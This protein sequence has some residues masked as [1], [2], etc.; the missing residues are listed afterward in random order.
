MTSRN[1]DD[2]SDELEDAEFSGETE[3]LIELRDEARKTV[4]CQIQTLGD[5]D[6]KASKIFRL[7]VI[8]IGVIV[9][10][11]SIVAQNGTAGS[12][13]LKSVE[14]F[15]NIYMQWS[16]VA[17]VLSTVF[18]ATTYTASELDVGVSSTNMAKLLKSDLPRKEIEQLL[19][20][21]YITR[22]NFNRSENIR[23]IPLLQLTI[24]LLITAVVLFALG[25][26][27]ATIGSVPWWLSGASS[28]LLLI[29]VVI[30][31]LPQQ[32]RRAGADIREWR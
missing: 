14:P 10:V 12:S 19:L 18:A 22:I 2:L 5:I 20:E 27:D 17:L 4:D 7:N 9:S 28:A 13:G 31:G 6:S 15:T 16:I 24:V 30:S 32:L 21:N 8:L 1:P 29:S 11:L 26:Y 25:T 3:L 23:N